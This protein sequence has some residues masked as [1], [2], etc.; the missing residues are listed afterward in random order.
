MI[1]TAKPITPADPAE[2]P[3]ATDAGILSDERPVDILVTGANGQ[4]GQEMR[5]AATG[6]PAFRFDFTDVEELDLTDAEAV[7][8][9]CKAIKPRFIVNC[10]AY[11]AVDKA[12][13]DVARCYLINRDAVANLAEAAKAVKANLIHISTDYVFDG[14]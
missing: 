7:K 12:E 13:E 8:A 5:Q 3:S 6:H 2:Q 11:T 1:Q 14:H 9:Y 4:L 10:A